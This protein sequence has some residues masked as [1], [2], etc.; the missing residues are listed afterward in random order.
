MEGF[1]FLRNKQAR[2]LNEALI[3]SMIPVWIIIEATTLIQ[4][5]PFNGTNSKKSLKQGM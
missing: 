2:S 3:I 1:A 4:S 5:Y